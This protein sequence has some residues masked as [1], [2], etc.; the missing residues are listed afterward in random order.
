MYIGRE[1]NIAQKN[2][3]IGWFRLQTRPETF[4]ETL[5][6]Y[7]NQCHQIRF[8]KDRAFDQMMEGKAY[9]AVS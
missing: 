5:G 2:Q 3:L 7:I 4:L 6:M 1:K 8:F 9:A